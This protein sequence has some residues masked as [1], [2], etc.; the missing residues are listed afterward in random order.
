MSF[1]VSITFPFDH[2]QFGEEFTTMQAVH[3]VS[4]AAEE[5]GF[6]SG[7]T[8]DHPVPSSRWLDAGGHYAQDPFVLL[9][10]AAAVTTKLKLQT[11]IVVLPYR[12]PFVTAR[13]VSS[14]DAFS[15]G[16]FIFGIGAGYLKAEYKALGVD[17]DAR[18]DLMDEY[19]KAMKAAWTGEDFTFEGTGYT[20]LGNR[21]RPAPVQKPHPPILVGGNSKRALRRTAELGD[22]W[23]PFFVPKMVT[24]TARTANISNDEDFKAALDYLYEHCEKIGRKEK[25]KI[26]LSGTFSM[27][28]DWSAQEA[29]DNFSH[30][31]ELG[32]DGSGASVVTDN[33]SE[34]CDQA[35][36]F[37]EEVIAKLD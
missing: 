3:D 32:A 10:M 33:R 16:R 27:Q 4:K 12:N 30:L 2:V 36:R 18:N 19:I 37:G 8:T 21:V 17:F 11:N 7:T 15:G 26:I 35:R 6:T 29:I 28:G 25:P 20:A 31:R 13:S 23:H 5:A 22:A 1:H 34:W 9:A 14:L 24:D